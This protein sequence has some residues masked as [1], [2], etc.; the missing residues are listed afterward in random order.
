MKISR[1]N[2]SFLSLI[3]ITTAATFLIAAIFVKILPSIS[4]KSLYFCQQLISNTLIQIPYPVKSTVIIV[5]LIALAL[6]SL[7]F[8]IQMVKTKRLV[9]S[10][11]RK[12]AALPQ[13]VTEI[14]NSLDLK[15]KIHVIED[16]NCF[17]FC[18]GILYPRILITT[19]LITTL[20]N[21]EIESV[22]LHEKAH[23]QNHD[24]LKMLFGKTVSWL[25]FFLPIFSELNKNMQATSEILADSFVTSFQKD[26]TY[27]RSALKKIL[28][29]PQMSFALTPA[30]AN[31]D[32]LEIRID[33]L[34][35]PTPRRFNASWMGIGT[36]ILFFSFMMFFLQTPVSAFQIGNSG[37][38][39]YF[40][41]SSDNACS[42]NCNINAKDP[43]LTPEHLFTPQIPQY[44]L[45]TP[46]K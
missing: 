21:K 26:D 46:H 40:I 2:G 20:T 42:Q 14:T 39:S 10:L 45:P 16:T 8:F 32:Y 19:A 25:F 28:T 13:G 3:F 37:E 44:K 35:N 7:S 27:L 4:A 38:E 12:R 41:C 15:E 33:R 36:S 18:A 43:V 11:L 6:G 5:L 23:I 24:P 31:P 34:I 30:I 17:S 1:F 22:L 29:T 9:K